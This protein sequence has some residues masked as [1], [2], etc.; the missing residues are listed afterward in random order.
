MNFR[1]IA[2]QAG[3]MMAAQEKRKSCVRSIVV[4]GV[5]AG[6][7]TGCWMSIFPLRAATTERIVTDYHTGL[8]ISGF[9]PVGYFTN[10]DAVAG[11]AEFEVRYAGATWR[12]INEGNRQAFIDHP[13]V[14]LPV[15]GGYDPMGVVRGIAVAGHPRVWVITGERLY[16]FHTAKT[17]EE[18]LAEPE[19]FIEL[20]KEE[21]PDVESTL[22]Q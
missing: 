18:F 19:R 4:F 17:R 7:L 6:V 20:A 15:F 2:A 8:A 21:W 13:E 10:S 11:R 22:V 1:I 5:L 12:F 14:Y 3:N 16:L 9:D